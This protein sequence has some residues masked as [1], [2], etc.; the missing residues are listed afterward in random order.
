MSSRGPFPSTYLWFTIAF[1]PYASTTTERNS[2]NWHF[3]HAICLSH[4]HTR[5]RTGWQKLE[6]I[7]SRALRAVT[8]WTKRERKVFIGIF[9]FTCT[10]TLARSPIWPRRAVRREGSSNYLNSILITLLLLLCAGRPVRSAV[11]KST[12]NEG[13]LCH[14]KSRPKGHLFSRRAPAPLG[15]PGPIGKQ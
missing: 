9:S 6:G 7:P 10:L 4:T 15:Q 3:F 1:L 2:R 11:F 12:T 14:V 5:A 13:Y 8:P